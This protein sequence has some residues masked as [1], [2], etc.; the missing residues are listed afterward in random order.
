MKRLT[1]VLFLLSGCLL[2]MNVQAQQGNFDPSNMPKVGVISGKVLDEKTG[3]TIEYATIGLYR[4]KDSVLL[5]GTISDNNGI[6]SLSEL[7][8]GM[9]YLEAGF[10]G[11]DKLRLNRILIS[12]QKTIVDVGVLKILPAAVDIDAV[13]IVAESNQVEYKIDKKV[14]TLSQDMTSAG[15]PVSQALENTPSIEVDIEGNVT[16]RGSPNFKVLID[17]KPSVLDGNEA[18][19]QIPASSVHSVEIITNPSAKYDPDGQPVS[20]TW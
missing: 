8:Y 11:Y 5:T 18:L 9:Y 17:G 6:F 3:H 16:L 1:I 2:C 4:Q 15:G 19:Q 12:P 14:V 20:L 13:E 7:P 10:L